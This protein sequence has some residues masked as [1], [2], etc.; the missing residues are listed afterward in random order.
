MLPAASLQRALRKWPVDLTVVPHG[1]QLRLQTGL[2]GRAGVGFGTAWR[3]FRRQPTEQVPPLRTSLARCRQLLWSPGL[4]W[5][6]VPCGTQGLA[7]LTRRG[8]A[9]GGER[10]RR[11]G[12]TPLGSPRLAVTSRTTIHGPDSTNRLENNSLP[13]AVA[14]AVISETDISQSGLSVRFQYVCFVTRMY[15]EVPTEF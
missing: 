13:N 6:V 5:N 15:W 1:G 7:S 3:P 4:C 9:G 11:S 2:V 10:R 14:E 8:C 12:R